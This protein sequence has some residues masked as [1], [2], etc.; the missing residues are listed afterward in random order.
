MKFTRAICITLVIVLVSSLDLTS[1]AVEEEIKVAC[2]QTEL[3]PCF[4]AAFIGSQP[5]AEC[6]GKLKEQQSCLCGYI[7]NPTFGQF[8]KNS[9]NVFTACGVPYPTC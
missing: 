7:Q 3:I 4:V 6:C 1:A 8:I 9:Q 5:S 2:V